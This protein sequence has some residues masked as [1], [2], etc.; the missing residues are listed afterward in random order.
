MGSDQQLFNEPC[1]HSAHNIQSRKML[2]SSN[3]DIGG[4][5]LDENGI[6]RDL[7]PDSFAHQTIL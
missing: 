6:L 3:I 4:K 1:W 7:K 2:F 5:M